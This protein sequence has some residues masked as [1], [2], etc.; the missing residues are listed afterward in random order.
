M[1]VGWPA[2]T[3]VSFDALPVAEDWTCRITKIHNQARDVEF[4]VVGS[5]T[6]PD[7]TGRSTE[8]FVSNS[9]RVVIEEDGWYLEAS[10]RHTRQPVP[11]GFEIKWTVYP[12]HTATY[13]AI[14]EDAAA[15]NA[16]VLA[17]GLPRGLHT[18]EL[19]VPD[20]RPMPQMR[21]L[22]VYNPPLDPAKTP[23][24]GPMPAAVLTAEQ[25]KSRTRSGPAGGS[26]ARSGV[27]IHREQTRGGTWPRSMKL[28]I[29]PCWSRATCP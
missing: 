19:T 1:G 20:G 17:Q 18:V 9:R 16:T 15:D 22:R 27:R 11:E 12:Q 14:V 28:R 23:E 4:E 3:R 6:G 29:I 25:K 5:V 26:S 21:A 10:R 2:I 7:G 8:R 13:E 24:V